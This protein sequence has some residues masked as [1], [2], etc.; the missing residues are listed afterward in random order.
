M[1]M[2]NAERQAAWRKRR[3][4]ELAA[5][6]NGARLAPEPAPDSREVEE[7]RAQLQGAQDEIKE[8]RATMRKL[9]RLAE[10]NK[11]M[12]RAYKVLVLSRKGGTEGEKAAATAALKRLGA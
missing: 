4:A 2:S 12:A 9:R 10:A 1:G 5:L 3:A 8:L 6:R 7:L 11:A